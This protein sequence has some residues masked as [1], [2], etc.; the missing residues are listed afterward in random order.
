MK[1]IE[2]VYMHELKK[3]GLILE[4]NQQ[5]NEWFWMIP[6]LVGAGMTA[7][8]YY[9]MAEKEGT[10]DVRDWSSDSQLELGAG[11][12]GTAAG[13]ILGRYLGKGIGWAAGKGMGAVKGAGKGA[14]AAAKAGKQAK[15][16]AEKIKKTPDTA[17]G[18]RRTPTGKFKQGSNVP[19]APKIGA[20]IGMGAKAGARGALK[21]GKAGKRLG[22]LGT[23]AGMVGGNIA[24]K[25][26]GALAG[27]YGDDKDKGKG[28]GANG[29]AKSDWWTSQQAKHKTGT[30]S[31]TSSI[32]DPIAKPEFAKKYPK[33][34][35]PELA[36]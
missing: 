2:V 32:P 30:R 5:L 33:L 6:T 13:G 17:A 7:Y 19:V 21:F 20:A 23:A 12:A 27:L 24:G 36:K 10:Y 28:K 11:V 9:N 16:A 1:I 18:G 26:L 31:A 35:K 22:H 15:K 8:D 14:A 4:D 25:K 34:A 3:R 29:K